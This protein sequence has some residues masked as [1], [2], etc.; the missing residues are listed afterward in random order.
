MGGIISGE[1]GIN[2]VK[3]G[4]HARRW[5]PRALELHAEMKRA[6]DPKGLLNPGKKV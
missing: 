5:S 4:Q 2:W 6:S 1:H 3:H